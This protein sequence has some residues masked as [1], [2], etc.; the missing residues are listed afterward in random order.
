MKL[1]V[2]IPTK[3]DEQNQY[4]ATVIAQMRPLPIELVVVDWGSAEPIVV[5]DG[6]RLIRVPL[7][8]AARYD[9]D[10]Y[11]AY[12]IATNVGIRRASGEYIGYFGNDT[13]VAADFLGWLDEAAKDLLYFIV[14]KNIDTVD[15]MRTEP[16]CRMT[17]QFH[18]SGG[19]VAHRDIWH[20]LRGYSE[21]L[22][23]WGWMERELRERA[24]MLGYRPE[25]VTKVCAYHFRH[26]R[27]AM[28]LQGRINERVLPASVIHP[29]G[30]VVNGTDWGLANE[31]PV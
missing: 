21:H 24:A 19:Q 6:V 28:R 3:N 5:P 13:F 8:V 9:Q 15:G 10:S 2:V 26:R 22:L 31:V 4:L 30:P 20:A 1:S 14:R 18:A 29:S 11:F 7:A 25:A 17:R 23:Y 12:I 16:I 27:P